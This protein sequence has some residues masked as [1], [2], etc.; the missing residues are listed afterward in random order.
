MD[1]EPSKFRILREIGKGGTSTVYEAEYEDGRRFAVKSIERQALTPRDWENLQRE[2]DIMRRVEHPNILKLH[3]IFENDDHFHFVLDFM[4]DGELFNH[5]VA[6]GRYTEADAS[7]IIR[8]ILQGIA[9]LHENGIAHRDLKPENIL[10]DHDRVVICDFGLSKFFGRGQLLLTQCGT[11]GYVAPEVVRG[12]VYT[13][14]VDIWTI[15]VI[16]YIL[17]SGIPPFSGSEDEMSHNIVHGRY[18]FP[19]ERFEGT[20]DLVRDFIGSLLRVDPADR[21]TA[22]TALTHPWITA[23]GSRLEENTVDLSGSMLEQSSHLW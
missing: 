11:S 23:E 9:Y 5:I 7:A 4:P 21:P 13:N 1:L 16:T 3:N 20:S 22:A 15:G 18:T 10:V 19:P 8:Q 17:V 14:G 2:A 12:G 6:R